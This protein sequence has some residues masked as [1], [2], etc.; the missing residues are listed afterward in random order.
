MDRQLFLLLNGSDSVF[1]DNCFRAITRT[2]TW[3]PLLVVLLFVV[4]KSFPTAKPLRSRLLS[5]LL[6]A[7]TFALVLTICD[8]TAS[9]LCK[10]L[11]HRLRPSHEPALY[12][13]VDLVNGR[14][15][16]LYGFFS[17]HAANSFGLT[18]FAALTLRNRLSAITL[19]L[20]AAL[21][22]YSRIY[23][24]YHYPGDIL[25]GLLFGLLTGWLIY[26]LQHRLFTNAPSALSAP[27]TTSSSAPSATSASPT[28]VASRYHLLLPA[29]LILTLVIIAIAA[30]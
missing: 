2:S 29:T 14:R 16:G 15:G 20:W 22:S 19:Y 11:F 5:L 26:K 17:S 10:P 23:L 30:I 3:I 7:V 1:L 13:L 27:G 24:G 28:A 12:G 9:T 8:Q 4:F 21:T 25:A 6:F 18:T